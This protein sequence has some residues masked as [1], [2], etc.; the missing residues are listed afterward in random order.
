MAPGSPAALLL[1]LVWA[2]WVQP[3]R[4]HFGAMRLVVTFGVVRRP[5]RVPLDGLLGRARCMPPLRRGRRVERRSSVRGG[6]QALNVA[7]DR[8]VDDAIGTVD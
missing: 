5:R 3:L 6:M 2:V 4:V 8:T 1:D 7:P